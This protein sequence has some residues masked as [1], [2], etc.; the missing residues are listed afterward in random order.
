[1]SSD[2]TETDWSD[3]VTAI[4]LEVYGTDKDWELEIKNFVEQN[5]DLKAILNNKKLNK[6][7]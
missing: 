3:I 2:R 1:M 6:I 7:N 4:Y 5:V